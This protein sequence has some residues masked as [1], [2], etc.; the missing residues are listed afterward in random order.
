MIRFQF[1]HKLLVLLPAAILMLTVGTK[2]SQ[3]ILNDLEAVYLP[4][5]FNSYVKGFNNPGFEYGTQG[6]VIQSNQGDSVVTTAAAHNGVRSAALGNGSGNRVASIAQQVKVPQQAYEV[7]YYQWAES[8]DSCSGTVM[9]S[10]NDQPYQHYNICQD[11]SN[12]KWVAKSIYLAPY[13]GQTV[14][15][16]LEYQS[17]TALNNYLYVDDF[18]FQVP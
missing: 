13:K 2:E 18:S 3:A 10:I 16:R 11:S 5:A 14:E 9:V 7:Q 4:V 15:F 17:S 8:L 6:W 1:K 12:A